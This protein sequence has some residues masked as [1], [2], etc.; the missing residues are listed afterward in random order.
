[1]ICSVSHCTRPAVVEKVGSLCAGHY[2]IQW[3]GR[4]PESRVLPPVEFKECLEPTCARAAQVGGLCISHRNSAKQGLIPIPE[5]AMVKL[6]PPCTFPGCEKLQNAKGL[7]Q[8]HYYQQHQGHPLTAIVKPEPRPKVVPKPRPP[9]VPCIGPGCTRVTSRPSGRCAAHDDQFRRRG[10]VWEIGKSR[11]IAATVC[12]FPGC[13]VVR[14][15]EYPFCGTHTNRARIYGMTPMDMA[16]LFTDAH[17]EVCGSE[18]SLVMDHDHS[19][20]DASVMYR[21]GKCNRG[22]LCAQCNSAFGMLGDSLDKARS[23]LAYAERTA[24]ERL[25]A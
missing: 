13:E 24:T 22:I 1:M 17:C 6:N 15:V 19:C 20:C 4:D 16:E 3:N 7:C 18:E 2:Q 8:S 23:L 5:G 25:A 11:P 10:V 14:N 12:P 21:C 9:R